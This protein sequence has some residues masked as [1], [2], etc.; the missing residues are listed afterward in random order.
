MNKLYISVLLFITISHQNIFFFNPQAE[1]LFGYKGEDIIVPKL[2]Q[3][4]YGFSAGAPI[5]KDKLFVCTK[6]K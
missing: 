5:I 6:Y 2:E 1:I 3:T 4:Q